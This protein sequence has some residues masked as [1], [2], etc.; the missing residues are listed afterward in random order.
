MP[1]ARPHVEGKLPDC[2]QLASNGTIAYDAKLTA[3]IAF[4]HCGAIHM[5]HCTTKDVEAI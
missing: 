3:L 4:V 1:L 2:D 5:L